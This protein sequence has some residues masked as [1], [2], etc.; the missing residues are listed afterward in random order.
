M[1]SIKRNP[2]M[3]DVARRAGVSTMTVSRA[4]K[5]NGQVTKETHE[6]II[7]AVEELGYVLRPDRRRVVITKNRLCFG[8]YSLRQQL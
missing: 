1:A 6:K 8:D 3:A 7:A 2:T 4:L 5:G